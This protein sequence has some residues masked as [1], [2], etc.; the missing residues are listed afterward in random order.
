MRLHLLRLTLLGSLTLAACGGDDLGSARLR[1]L[2]TGATRDQVLETI[3]TGPLAATGA[4]T[5]R[6]AQ[7]HRTQRYIVNGATYEVIWYREEPGSLADDIERGRETPIL[8]E[9]DT[10]VGWGWSLYEKKAAEVGLPNPMREKAR[11]DSISR[12]QQ[13]GG[14]GA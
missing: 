14:T 3:G 11:L 10:L 8:L 5:L 4:D 12:S 13:A 2:E 1:S 6:L 7:G 9:A